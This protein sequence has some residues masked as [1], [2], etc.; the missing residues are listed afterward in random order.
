MTLQKPYCHRL[1][2]FLILAVYIAP[3]SAQEQT[4]AVSGLQATVEILRDRWGIAHIYAQNESD[5]FFARS[6]SRLKMFSRLPGSMR[7]N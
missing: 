4:L 5:L 7:A 1:S 3:V 6:V 2:V